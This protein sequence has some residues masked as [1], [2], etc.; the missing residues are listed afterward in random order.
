MRHGIGRHE[1][2]EPEDPGEKM[3]GNIALFSAP[4][5][6]LPCFQDM[7]V[8][9]VNDTVKEGPRTGC[10]IEDQDPVILLIPPFC[11]FLG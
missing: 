9:Q 5:A 6:R 3:L 7:A 1:E 10:G 4:A 11:H 2:L 8:D